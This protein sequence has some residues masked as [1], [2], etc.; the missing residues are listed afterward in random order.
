MRD[1][2]DKLLVTRPRW[3]SGSPMRGLRRRRRERFDPE[4]A[5]R[6][7]PMSLGRG[8]KTQSEYFAPLLRFLRSR[9]GEHWD[10]VYSEI[11]TRRR[12]I[13]ARSNKTRS[14]SE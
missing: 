11:R 12:P 14:E 5:P 1:D 7:E 8:F 2:M 10:S 4:S 3:G 6:R 13:S 9:V